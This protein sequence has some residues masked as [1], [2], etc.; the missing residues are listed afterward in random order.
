MLIPTNETE[1]NYNDS[2]AILVKNDYVNEVRDY[3]TKE[4]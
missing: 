4:E 2:I 3:F 1:L